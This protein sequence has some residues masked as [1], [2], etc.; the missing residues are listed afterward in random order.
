MNKWKIEIILKSGERIS[1]Y[2]EGEEVD[3]T[4]VAGTLLTG[5]QHTLNAIA[6]NK[7][8][9]LWY[10]VGEVAACVISVG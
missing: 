10:L 5:H 4:A 8:G 3:S 9:Q 6:A 2:Y 7:N 1:G